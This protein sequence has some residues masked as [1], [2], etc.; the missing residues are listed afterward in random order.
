MQE[1]KID[2]DLE[3]P[4]ETGGPF[5]NY[6]QIDNV[7]DEKKTILAHELGEVLLVDVWAT[8]CPPCQK[9]MGHNQ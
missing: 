5:S 6:G 2:A 8:W 7:F 1:E 3:I 9:P 4:L